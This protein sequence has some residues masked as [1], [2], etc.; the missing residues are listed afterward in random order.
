MGVSP[1]QCVR[2]EWFQL[3]VPLLL[4]AG[5]GPIA[6][7]DAS[8]PGEVLSAMLASAQ[9]ACRDAKEPS[10]LRVPL[11]EATWLCAVGSEPRVVLRPP[12]PL[13]DVL[14]TSTRVQ[15]SEDLRTVRLADAHFATPR[16][17][18]LVGQVTLRNVPLGWA[19]PHFAAWPRACALGA[20][21]V[22]SCL[23]GAV[24]MLRVPSSRRAMGVVRGASGPVAA[25]AVL[26]VLDQRGAVDGMLALVP[27][28]A[29][30]ATGLV[31][32]VAWAGQAFARRG[33]TVGARPRA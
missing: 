3:V 9:Q 24:F 18:A 19:K 4:V 13:S 25:L 14:V 15:L 11:V 2:R 1:W 17:D 20:A 5:L 28:G 7:R 10:V 33:A 27:I 31:A 16:L 29:A 30:L 8:R 12:A 32:G 21:L 6:V 23:V 22:V 26:R